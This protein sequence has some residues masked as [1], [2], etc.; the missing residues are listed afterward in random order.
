[1]P[2][3]SVV[4]SPTLIGAFVA[5]GYAAVKIIEALIGK[6]FNLKNGGNGKFT[7]GDRGHLNALV[8]WHKKSDDDGVPLA[9]IPRRWEETQKEI[10]AIQRGQ[11]EIMAKVAD[12]LERIETRPCPRGK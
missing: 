3:P 7:A 1:M 10:L 2:D 5:G 8:D 12:T 6:L 9:Y 11:N 4:V